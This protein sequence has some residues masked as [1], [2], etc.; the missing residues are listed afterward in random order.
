MMSLALSVALWISGAGESSELTPQKVAQIHA[1]RDKA[2]TEI[3]KKY[4]DKKPAQLTAAERNEREKERRAASLGIIKKAGTDDKAFSR[5]EAT[6]SREDRAATQKAEADLKQAGEREGDE[7]EITYDNDSEGPVITES[8]AGSG[9]K[10]PK[11]TP[12]KSAAKKRSK[13]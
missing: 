2:Y 9:K 12:N 1:E 3:D 8:R 13:R 4:G 7:P 10:S 6:M 5:Y 11:K